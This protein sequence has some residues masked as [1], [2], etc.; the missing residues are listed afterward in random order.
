MDELSRWWRDGG[1][2]VCA[3]V[4]IGGAGKT[5]I[6]ERFLRIL[7]GV[8]ADGPDA[9][10]DDSLPRRN[11]VFVFSFYNAP[12]PS[13]FFAELTA[14]L[15][16]RPYDPSA[17]RPSASKALWTL[18][19]APEVL[20]VLDGLERVQNDGA[21]G[22]EF[23]RITDEA[24]RTFVRRAGDCI[25]PRVSVIISTRFVLG[26]LAYAASPCYRHIAVDRISIDAC[27]DLLRERGVSGGRSSLVRLARRGGRHALTVDLVGG[28]I[29]YFGAG[30]P[31]AAPQLPSPDELRQ[32][33]ADSPD[34]RLRYVAEQNARFNR[35][36]ASYRAAMLEQAPARLALLE[37][38]C[39]FRLGVDAETLAAIFTGPGKEG[40]SPPELARLASG[41]VAAELRRLADMR[42]IELSKDG[43]YSIHPAIRD[44]F[45]ESMDPDV[46]RAGHQAASEALQAS[47]GSQPGR[48]ALPDPANLDHLE[49]IFFHTLEAGRVRAA[50]GL[51]DDTGLLAV[52]LVGHYDRG[53]RIL[54]ALVGGLDPR[55]ASRPDDLDE[56]VWALILFYVGGLSS[57]AGATR[58]G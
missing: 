53:Q 24:L 41:A 28:Y 26:D 15:E 42:L 50:A 37:R 32:I 14:W 38:I 56:N 17:E 13:V 25:L 8:L 57:G 5:A 9:P 16:N 51:L 48:R 55:D 10:K 33:V 47:L 3:L 35:V 18:Q 1:N 11:A 46:A 44:G 6:A 43:K 30:D 27:V 54:R 19:R 58:A 45:R 29:A 39:L 4:G 49:E 7:P 36:A 21:R 22:G 31:S 2:G 40:I 12:N 23:G 52:G 20:L 34:S